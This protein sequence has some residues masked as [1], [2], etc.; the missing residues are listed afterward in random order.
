MATAGTTAGTTSTLKGY[1]DM[2]A[3]KMAEAK[4]RLEQVEAKAKEKGAQAEIAAVSSL[5]T[6][7]QNIDRRLQDLKG[8]HA[9]NVARARADIDADVATFKASVDQL[10]G[11]FKTQ[12][13]K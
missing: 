4:A 13:K 12:S 1:E 8:T 6:A 9:S 7:K 5:K 10:A 11:K 2:V 3:A